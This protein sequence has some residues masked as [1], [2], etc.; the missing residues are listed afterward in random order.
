VLQTERVKIIVPTIETSF[1][2]FVLQE[3]GNI[4]RK[5]SKFRSLK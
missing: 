4:K 1:I 2:D 3:E 5:R